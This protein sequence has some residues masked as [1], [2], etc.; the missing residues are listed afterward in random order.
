VEGIA[1]LPLH[2]G[3]VPSWL[4]RYMERLGRA[5]VRGIIDE[6]GAS[7]LV[8]RLSDPLWFQAFNNAIGMDWDSSGSTTVVLRILK[9]ISWSEDLGVLVL[10]GKGAES[11]NIPFES[12]DAARR[13]GLGEEWGREIRRIS[14]IGAKVDGV[15]LQDGHQLYIHG[16]IVSSDGYWAIIQQGMDAERGY[17]RRY[18]ISRDSFRDPPIDPHSG[19][20]SN[21]LLKPL[22]L[23]D[24]ASMDT[25][26]AI[27]DLVSQSVSKVIRDIA[28]ADACIRGRRTLVGDPCR[29]VRRDF[30]IKFYRPVR[31]DREMIETINRIQLEGARRIIEI[32]GVR[33]V[34]SETMRALVLVADLIYG[35]T[36]SN[37]DPV[38]H[39]LDPFKYS[40]AQGGKDGVPY[41]VR[42]DLLERTIMTLEEAIERAKL[43]DRDKAE[44][45]KRLSRYSKTIL[46][47][48]S[49]LSV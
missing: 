34:G 23:A 1:D 7:E 35:Y 28:M 46:G 19:V 5:I 29:G 17:A 13:L 18:H 31:I 2:S 36:P 33:G 37:R 6:Y 8:R 47:G 21:Q 14:Y 15:L 25:I 3:S 10:G 44:S 39:P 26:K 20:A 12:I 16:V 40:Y 22:N 38:S 43:G 11:R 27:E 41:R 30:S 42:R 32:L 9:G 48:I 24:R 4:Y 45:L 49:D